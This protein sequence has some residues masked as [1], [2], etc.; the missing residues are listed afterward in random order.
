[1]K[2]NKIVIKLSVNQLE[3]LR[4]AV[5][6]TAREYERVSKDKAPSFL[7]GLEGLR[8]KLW[9]EEVIRQSRG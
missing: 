1:M 7:K 5:S 3:D 6:F 9:T 4:S 8:K 2:R